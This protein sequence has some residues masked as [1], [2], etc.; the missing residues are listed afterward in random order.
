MNDNPLN[1]MEGIHHLLDD[2]TMRDLD[3]GDRGPY[4]PSSDYIDD[5]PPGR[6]IMEVTVTGRQGYDCLVCGW[7][8]EGHE[9]T[10]L[11]AHNLHAPGYH[12]AHNLKHQR[13]CLVEGRHLLDHV[14]ALAS[15]PGTVWRDADQTFSTAL[16]CKVCSLNKKGEPRNKYSTMQPES[17]PDHLTSAGHQRRCLDGRY[18]LRDRGVSV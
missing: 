1:L 9:K 2:T 15:R 14:R 10:S 13:R 17:V 3:V 4:G 12:E 7:T 5:P 11:H 8:K 18:G 6:M 16:L